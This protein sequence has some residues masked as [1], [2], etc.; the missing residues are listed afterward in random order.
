MEGFIGLVILLV[1]VGGLYLY[2]R[3]SR[4]TKASTPKSGGSG[5]GSRGEDTKL[6]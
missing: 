3:K 4:E 1:V 6:D 5:G 2:V